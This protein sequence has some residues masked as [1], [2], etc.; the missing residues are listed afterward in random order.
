MN[1]G[2][3]IS[4]NNLTRTHGDEIDQMLAGIRGNSGSTLWTA[5][6]RA[7]TRGGKPCG[8]TRADAALPADGTD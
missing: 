3:V 7:A 2:K 5:E 6:M 1:R 4:L 8:I